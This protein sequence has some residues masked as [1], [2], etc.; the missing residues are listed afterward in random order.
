MLPVLV[1]KKYY[2][3]MCLARGGRERDREK[4]LS[5]GIEIEISVCIEDQ[6][7]WFS[8][9]GHLF[10][11]LVSAVWFCGSIPVNSRGVG[12]GHQPVRGGRRGER[13]GGRK[14]G[15]E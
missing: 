8:S 2:V 13:D 1:G 15:R 6:Y 14:C 5:T 7:C 3:Y 12:A 10:W 9:D 4:N 11:G